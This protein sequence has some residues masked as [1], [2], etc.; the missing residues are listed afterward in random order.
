VFL[1]SLALRAAAPAW[2]ETS[3]QLSGQLAGKVSGKVLSGRMEDEP[4]PGSH[5]APSPEGGAQAAANVNRFE[6]A[7][8][9]VASG[10]E[11]AAAEALL[12][13]AHEQPQDD[14]APEALFEAGVLY[15]EH[16]N[17]P[18]AARRCYKELGERYPHSRLLRRAQQRLSQL[19]IALRSGP[20]PLITFQ[21]ILRK[22]AE[23]SKE[24]FL[25][26]SEL[27]TAHPDFSLADQVLFLL[28]DTA[29]RSGD[30]A[31]LE[32]SLQELYRRFPRSVWAAQGHRL[33]AEALLQ[34][35]HIAAARAE[36]RVLLDYPGPLWPL[37]S[38]E[39]LVS[40]QRAARLLYAAVAAGLYLGLCALFI[41]IRHYR[42]LWPPPFELWYYAPVAALLTLA[43]LPGQGGG[44]APLVTP[45]WELG[46]FGTGLS[47]LA[48]ASARDA[49]PAG[50]AARDLFR[51]GLGLLSRAMAVAAVCYLVV[52]HHGLIEVIVETLQN[53]PEGG[54]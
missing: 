24:R 28:A 29:L 49:A 19:D 11:A 32:R 13:L 14:I 39:G 40:C 48:A 53:G 5:E 47:W 31:G 34:A 4:K 15:E 35:H 2:A 46:L 10:K 18:E 52:Y 12:R 33:H 38:S 17:D 26:L 7:L 50:R 27:L 9:L 3:G 1:L 43:A 21:A 45:L 25:R 22:S 41:L 30:R 44:S 36:Y 8:R 6:A 51:L 42:R 23:G 54:G 37:I 16:I 20:A